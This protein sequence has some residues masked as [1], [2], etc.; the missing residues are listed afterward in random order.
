MII[1]RRVVAVLVT[2][3]SVA[4]LLAALAG[5]VGVWVIKG[6]LT[7]E[8]TRLLDR[9]DAA[10]DV[11]GRAL[12][13]ADTSLTRA[14]DSVQ[15]MKEGHSQLVGGAA[16]DRRPALNLIALS[17]ND[18]LMPQVRDARGRLQ[19]AAE[20]AV[21]LQSLLGG[22]DQLPLVSVSRP[23]ADRIREA[24]DDLTQVAGSA[25]AL[26]GLLTGGAGGPAPAAVGS[27]VDNIQRLLKE[28]RS[29]IEEYERKV[30]DARQEV[31]VVRARALAW[32][33]PG[34][35]IVSLVLFWIA[36]SQVSVLAHVRSWLWRG[37]V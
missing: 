10:L 14:A 33:G 27:R 22:I 17:L 29:R 26:R 25:E 18:G 1:I 24:N 5:G 3:V 20:V 19:A 31:G 12:G 15:K 32:I 6:R 23:E 7:A 36:L 28:V 8:T 35:L 16:Q 9:A 34:T 37:R 4:V 30:T 21:A 2:V 11:A 13:D